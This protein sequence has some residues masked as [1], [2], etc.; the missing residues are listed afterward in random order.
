MEIR[1][2]T[3]AGVLEFETRLKLIKT[4]HNP[5]IDVLVENDAY[6]E[7][8]A[9]VQAP[10]I[11]QFA[12]REDVGIYLNVILQGLDQQ[13]I[14]VDSD[15]GLWTWLSALF[16]DVVCPPGNDGKRPVGDISRYVF[17]PSSF[18]K[19]YRH[20]LNNPYRIVKTHRS[21]LASARVVLATPVNAPGEAVEQIASRQ[22]FISNSALL[23]LATK[24]YVDPSTKSLKEGSGGSGGGS[25]RRFGKVLAQ[26]DRTWDTESMTTQELLALL[27][28]EFNKFIYAT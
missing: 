11:A 13:E 25:P 22:E 7:Y 16:F 17:N 8:I 3:P 23:A 18:Q 24:L 28:A 9:Q 15:V 27:P 26:L 21:A 5:P 2:F 4:G 1:R 19:Y 6:T 14:Q 20:L 12:T 10:P